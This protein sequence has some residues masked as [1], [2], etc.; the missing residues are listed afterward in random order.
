MDYEVFV[1]NFI[2]SLNHG[3]DY[4]VH[5]KKNQVNVLLIHFGENKNIVHKMINLN[6]VNLKSFIYHLTP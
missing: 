4:L 2:M 1:S 6:L 5:R 3:N